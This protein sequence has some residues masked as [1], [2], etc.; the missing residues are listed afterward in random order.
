MMQ[1]LALVMVIGVVF[2]VVFMQASAGA[3]AA[4]ARAGA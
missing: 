4:R 1:Q 3:H 2:D